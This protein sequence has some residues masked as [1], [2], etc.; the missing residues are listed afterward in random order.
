MSDLGKDE[1]V[2]HGTAIND[3]WNRIGVNG[4]KSCPKL[5]H[6]AHCRNCPTY[7]SGAV[8][9]LHRPLPRDYREGWTSHF[10]KARA[11]EERTTHSAL[12]FRIGDDWF[13][14][15]TGGID[16]IAE[17]RPVHS[18]PHPRGGSILGLV[19]IRGELIVCVS[20][21]KMLGLPEASANVGRQGRFVVIRRDTGRLAFPVDEIDRMH[22]YHPNDLRDA[23]ATISRFAAAY[24]TG[25]LS[26]NERFVACL[27]DQRIARSLDR[28]AA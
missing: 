19:N 23:P 5:E 15:P 7:A 22:R 12:F 27:D 17:P 11:V 3:C 14:L 13:A 25:I 4:D 21:A 24:I 10:A 1:L 16:E 18:L 2:E 28:T 9:L 26:W 8:A 20:L 6:V